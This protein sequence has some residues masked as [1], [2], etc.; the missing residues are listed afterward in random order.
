M[1]PS[2][3][4]RPSAE[5]D[6]LRLLE[7][8]PVMLWTADADGRWVH[9]NRQWIEF[10]G[11]MDDVG[12]F[13]FEAALHPDDLER[14]ITCW[15]QSVARAEPYEIEYRLRC[16]DG[17]YRW[18]LIRGV[19][20]ADPQGRGIA[21]VG[22]CTDIE[23]QKQ[24][25]QAAMAMR[26]SAVRA[27]GLALETR[28][29][30]THGHTDRVTQLALR[31]GHAL[32]L[33]DTQLNALRL[34]AYLHDIGK[35][36]IPD[37]LLLKPGTLD[38]RE[39]QLMR[40]HPVEGERFAAA[41]GFLPPEATDLIRH[42]HERWDGAGYPDGQRGE[43]I[44][45]LAR[46]FSVVDVYDAL[47]SE[48]PYKRAWTPDEARTELRRQAGT[49]FDAGMVETFLTLLQRPDDRSANSGNPPVAP[50]PG[51]GPDRPPN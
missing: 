9:V 1:T 49:Q 18:F 48:R 24:A 14:T 11:L 28:D 17:T 38:E 29:R 5:G 47:L 15:R 45:L 42:H 23:E 40:I 25:R 50:A 27:L 26:E 4:P 39:W 43:H 21:W 51:D 12:A 30:E 16:H 19:P 3:Q 8:M 44:P 36:A 31:L 2:E 32:H 37:A 33:S 46:L 20:V 34:G 13:G 6:Y 41:L 35:L 10:T 22:T 7:A